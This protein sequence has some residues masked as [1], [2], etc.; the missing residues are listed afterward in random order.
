M[1]ANLLSVGA[2]LV[3]VAQGRRYPSDLTDR[4]W[5]LIEQLRCPRRCRSP[6]ADGPRCIQLKCD[7]Q[8]QRHLVPDPRR[9]RLAHDGRNDLPP[10]WT[11]YGYFA[12]WRDDGTLDLVH[13]TLREELRKKTEKRDGTKRRAEPTAGI[14]DS[15]IPAWGRHR[16][17]GQAR[18]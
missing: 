3:Y 6:P 10:W 2:A 16:R 4:Q 1:L 11:V 9:V 14:I 13:D 15:L 12:D 17:K 7:H 18:L 5:A 8:N